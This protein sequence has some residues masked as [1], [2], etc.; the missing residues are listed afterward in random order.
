[1]NAFLAPASGSASITTVS[2]IGEGASMHA[3]KA[4]LIFLVVGLI[5]ATGLFLLVPSTRPGFVKTWFHKAE[6]FGPSTSASDALD[7]FKQAIE[8]RNYEAASLYLSGDYKEW[9]DKGRNDAEAL[10][11]AIDDL[12]AAMQ[13]YG[14]KSD[15]AKFVLYMLEPFPADFKAGTPGAGDSVTVVLSWADA[16]VS[17]QGQSTDALP[18]SMDHKIWHSMLPNV[19]LG[20]SPTLSVTVT[21]EKDGWWR[22]QFPLSTSA[23]R[24]IQD[25]VDYLRKNGSNFKN[26]INGIKTDVKNDAPTKENFESSLNTKLEQS[27]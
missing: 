22:I 2:F 14:V 3:G 1:M 18:K 16:L 9:F 20:V 13:T 17:H 5:G 11:K 21:K 19:V 24:R 26:A 6:G 27:K 15:K 8:K 25:T 10:H 4:L 23:D 12:R 7:K